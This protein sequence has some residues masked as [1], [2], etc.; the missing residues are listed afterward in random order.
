MKN[1]RRIPSIIGVLLLLVAIVGGVYLTNS[2]T[3]V[4]TKASG[5][6]SPTG[7]QITNLTNKSAD[8]SFTTAATCNSNLQ[9]DGKT[10]ADARFSNSNKSEIPIRTHYF[11]VDNLTASTNY[12]FLIISGGQNF[13]F[14]D[15]NLST[16]TTP[17]TNVPASKLAWGKVFS[18]TATPAVYAIVYLNIPGALPLSSYVTTDG[19]WNIPLSASFNEAKN[20]WFTIIPSTPEDIV[21]ISD[22]GLPTQI[23]NNTDNNNPVPDITIGQDSFTTPTPF[24]QTGL[25]NVDQAVNQIKLSIKNPLNQEKISTSRPDFFGTA[26]PQTSLSIL[27]KSKTTTSG[28]VSADNTGQWHWS[29]PASLVDGDYTITV[30]SSTEEVTTSFSILN[31]GSGDNTIAFSA[32]SSATIALPS[33]TIVPTTAV[34]PTITPTI[35]PTPTEIVRVSHPSTASGTPVSGSTSVTTAIILTSMVLFVVSYLWY[36]HY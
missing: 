16:A 7:L 27:V 10:Y 32:S 22:D 4:Q 35:E 20:N 31:L 1:E 30:S 26:T 15:F 13:N 29:P 6:C 11:Q 12:R 17:S 18:S 14:P 8:I 19:N 24:T 23:S 28:T 2:K 21:V 9:I 3:S 36:S 25:T 5:D 33:P 34:M